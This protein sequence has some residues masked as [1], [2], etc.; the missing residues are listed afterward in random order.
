MF[1]VSYCVYYYITNIILNINFI[2]LSNV[3]YVH[4]EQGEGGEGGEITCTVLYIKYY[5]IHM[6][7]TGRPA[8]SMIST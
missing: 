4:R 2:M 5:T 1:T 3:N 8:G 7:I 6:Y